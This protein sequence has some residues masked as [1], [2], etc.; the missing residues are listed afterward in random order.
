MSEI[1]KLAGQTM[2]Y[3]LSSV[4]ARML[5]Y[6]LTPILTYIM[7]DAA[8]V[9]DYGD[10]STLYAFIAFINVLFTY[11]FETGYF[12]FSN[13]EG[14]EKDSLFQTTF[15]SLLISSILLF[16]AFGL[17]YKQINTFLELDGHPEYILW[18]FGIIALDA[19]AIIPFAKLRQNNRPKRYAFIKLGGIIV[20]VLL[21]IFFLAYLPLYFEK[22]PQSFGHEW[23]A[24]QNKIGLLL[25]ANLLMN[26][27]VVLMLFPEWKTFRFKIDAGLW[28]K[29][30]KYASP[31]IIIGLAGMVN[32]VID[33]ILLQKLL[34]TTPQ[35]AKMIVGIYSANYKLA[36]FI[37]LFIQAFKLAAE[38][39]FFKKAQDKN[40]PQLYAKVMKWFVFTMC[41]AFLFTTLFIDIWKYIIQDSYRTGLGVVWILLL[42]NIALGMYYNLSVW[43]KITDRM[44]AGIYITI[45]GAIVTLVGN[46]IFIPYYGMY[47]A[48]WS[49]FSAYVIMVVVSYIAG[50]KYFPV[51][52][53]LKSILGLV[54]LMLTFYGLHQGILWV[55]AANTP[56]GVHFIISISSGFVLFMT[57]IF[58]VLKRFKN[59]LTGIKIIQKL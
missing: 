6:L 41:L 13:K 44:R 29:V 15:G 31:M 38:P 52:Y 24:A 30:F 17:F 47:A 23:F 53:P 16:I 42:A 34:P 25:L 35:I 18:A 54:G 32:E 59:D 33:R 12:R 37:T 50:Q 27:F 58:I 56:V 1:K 9:A 20:N 22:N 39:F 7:S 8:G 51:P 40:S 21:A 46:Y 3:G 28:K 43:Y 2:W 19:I 14:I 57:Y 45:I 48:A 4:G 5:N 11:G 10:Y 55:F 36:I 26:V 49:T